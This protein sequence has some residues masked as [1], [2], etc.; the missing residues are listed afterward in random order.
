MTPY[1]RAVAVDYDGTL[2]E[3]SPPAPLVV[4]AIMAYRGSG[5]RVLLVTGRI[6]EELR[7]VWPGAESAVDAVV[8]E[9]GAVIWLPGAGVRTAA[10]PVPRELADALEARGVPLARGKVLLAT[11]AAWAA[12]ALE[13]IARL[14]LEVQLVYNRSALMLLP[15]GVS[16]GTGL[17]AVLDEL[18][19]SRHSTVGV[20]DAENDHSLLET[21]EIGVAVANAVPSLQA[22]ADIVLRDAQGAGVRSLLRGAIMS[23][24]VRVQ[25]KRWQIRIGTAADGSPVT[26]PGSQTNLLITGGAASGKSHMAG[27][28]IERL[29]AMGYSVWVIDPEGD[30]VGLAVLPNTTV[31]GIPGSPAGATAELPRPRPLE[32]AV[33]DLSAQ[34]PDERPEWCRRLLRAA[35]RLRAAAGV[36][37]WVVLDEAH[38]V[39]EALQLLGGAAD[40]PAT[41]VCLVTYRPGDFQPRTLDTID[42][43]LTLRERTAEIADRSGGRPFAPDPRRSS[44][45]RHW[46]KYLTGLLPHHQRF[47]FRSADRLTGASAAN[48][49]EFYHELERCEPG[50][51]VHHAQAHD[52]SR[53]TEAVLQDPEL[54]SAFRAIENR[55]AGGSEAQIERAR[56]DLLA[57]IERRYREPGEPA[58]G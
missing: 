12:V 20:G 32:S 49:P 36:P 37:H 58:A 27:L 19:I 15:S 21:C 28:L 40:A 56:R 35:A 42:Y 2:T 54:A 55:I 17:L 3:H 1:F 8:A 34:N 4:D 22:H 46:H 41:G 18:R 30:H 29:V 33:F 14:G 9:N 24:G 16:K 51:L 48:I 10:Q 57:D 23:S 13:E 39:P 47:F 52:F 53:W 25:P 38:L 31:F 7:A 11:D 45:V 50:V 26:L 43:V 44:H 5:G 6:L